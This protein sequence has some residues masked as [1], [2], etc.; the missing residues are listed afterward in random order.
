MKMWSLFTVSDWKKPNKTKADKSKRTQED[1]AEVKKEQEM[2]K[3]EQE[4]VKNTSRQN[5]GLNS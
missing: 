2:V 5:K 3:K 1:K 4:M